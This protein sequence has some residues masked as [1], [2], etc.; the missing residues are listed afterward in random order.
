GNN[1]ATAST[2]LGP[3]SADLATSKSASPSAN[4]TP[5]TELTYTVGVTN[6]GPSNAGT[7][8][9]TD[10]IP[11]QTTFLRLTNG[12]WNCG[13]T[14]PTVGGA[15]TLTCTIASLASGASSTNLTLVVKVGGSASGTI[16]NT[17][18]SSL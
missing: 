8:T 17:A 1:A 4:V 13:A 7:V 2:T 11:A 3:A 5:G 6:N 16:N 14:T 10:S 9:L 15:G 12:G 18:G